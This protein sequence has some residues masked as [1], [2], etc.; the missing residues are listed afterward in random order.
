MKSAQVNLI[1]VLKFYTAGSVERKRGIANK[2]G[3]NG[4][5]EDV[6]KELREPIL[7]WSTLTLHSKSVLHHTTTLIPYLHCC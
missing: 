1:I 2:N 3:E 4:V 5:N 7:D 6:R